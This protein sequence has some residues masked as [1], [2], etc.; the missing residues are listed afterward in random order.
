M[1]TATAQLLQAC[2][3]GSG[4]YPPLPGS[5]HA[6]QEATFPPAHA[7]ILTQPAA[8]SRVA[9]FGR[10]THNTFDRNKA[11]KGGPG[12]PRVQLAASLLAVNTSVV[13]KDQNKLQSGSSE[14]DKKERDHLTARHRHHREA[15]PGFPAAKQESILNPKPQEG[16]QSPCL[17]LL[18]EQQPH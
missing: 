12:G 11:T 6:W 7:D 5:S 3:S 8:S 4:Q 9:G 14:G 2:R 10:P 15:Q 18:Q 1:R 13:V 17:D 16:S